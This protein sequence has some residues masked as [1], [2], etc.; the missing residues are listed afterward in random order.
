[1]IDSLKVVGSKMGDGWAKKKESPEGTQFGDRAKEDDEDKGGG[2]RELFPACSIP[3][4]RT[5]GGA[6]SRLAVLA[7][8]KRIFIIFLIIFSLCRYQVRC[9]GFRQN[10]RI[11]K[12]RH[13]RKKSRAP[14]IKTS[15]QGPRAP[16]QLDVVCWKTSKQTSKQLIK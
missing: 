16:L 11:L 14:W 2:K 5:Q 7:S 12:T 13:D 9:L 4:Q 10:P 15:L 3:K 1:M 6:A 8:A